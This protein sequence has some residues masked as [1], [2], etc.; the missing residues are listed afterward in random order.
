MERTIQSPIARGLS[1]VAR[2]LGAPR[3]MGY[4]FDPD[5]PVAGRQTSAGDADVRR[6]AR[7][8]NR[9][10][11]GIFADMVDYLRPKLYTDYEQMLRDVPELKTGL[12]VLHD[13]AFV[14]SDRTDRLVPNPLRTAF[15][16]DARPEIKAL[17][18][19][20]EQRFNPSVLIPQLVMAAAKMGDAWG[21]LVWSRTGPNR[22]RLERIAQ[23]APQCVRG[24]PS[25]FGDV[26]SWQVS[27][28]GHG[29]Q[30][31]P[32]FNVFEILH[33]PY[34]ASWNR[35]YGTSILEAGR[36]NWRR[37]EAAQDSVLLAVMTSSSSRMAVT[38]PIPGLANPDAMSRWRAELQGDSLASELFDMDGVARLRLITHLAL[39]DHVIPYNASSMQPPGLHNVPAPPLEDLLE[40]LHSY[41]SRHFVTINVPAALATVTRDMKA[42]NALETQ[43]VGF[44][45]TV[46]SLQML[47]SLVWH[48]L[49]TRVI[50]AAGY[51]TST[52]SREYWLRL[53]R[54]ERFDAEVRARSLKT[55]TGALH[56]CEQFGLDPK[57]T[58]VNVFGM[59][60]DEVDEALTDVAMWRHTATP[61]DTSDPPVP[62]EQRPNNP[63]QNKL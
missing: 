29:M 39:T 50:L 37:E 5:R 63:D 18:T 45:K 44:A 62:A 31:G 28:I 1:R 57:W 6:Q 51:S 59:S 27:P 47:A 56:L 36:K 53:P 38:Y 52:T 61:S 58:L 48:D 23:L 19:D 42:A 17:L 15:A 11:L 41:Q 9:R 40:I 60:P 33:V 34:D 16:H 3:T 14:E 13:H 25:D 12:K 22:Y 10:M 21:Q 2:S 4:G 8:T 24:I 35:M 43:G 20:L 55:T 30:Q 46:L 32:H 26:G 7:E 54:V 49:C